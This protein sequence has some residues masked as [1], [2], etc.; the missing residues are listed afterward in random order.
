[1]I[2]L[3]R[4]YPQVFRSNYV[5][6]VADSLLSTFKISLPLHGYLLIGKWGHSPLVIKMN[7][8]LNWR[9]GMKLAALQV[10]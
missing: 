1:M 8:D 3:G 7:Q 6:D 10:Y 2:F 4:N 5:L 9:L